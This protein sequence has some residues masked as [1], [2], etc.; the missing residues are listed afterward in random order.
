[1]APEVG[2]VD[3]TRERM[4]LAGIGIVGLAICIGIAVA[5]S[6]EISVWQSALIAAVFGGALYAVDRHQM[7]KVLVTTERSSGTFRLEPTSRTCVRILAI[8][9]LASIPGIVLSGVD[10]DGVS[11]IA[12]IYGAVAIWACLDVRLLQR[13]ERAHE[14]RVLRR[15]RWMLSW[16]A[17]PPLV[18]DADTGPV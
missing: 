12:G 17:E 6:A 3:Q 1:M 9:V 4:L 11:G 8:G 14:A 16:T 13:W 2:L 5:G 10:G 18:V 15:P 7:L